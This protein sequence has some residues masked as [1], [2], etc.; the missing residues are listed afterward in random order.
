MR[1]STFEAV[2][3]IFARRFAKTTYNFDH[4]GSGRAA[5]FW[6]QQLVTGQ[7]HIPENCRV[8]YLAQGFLKRLSKQFI[9]F[10]L[11]VF[12]NFYYAFEMIFQIFLEKS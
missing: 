4:I 11:F 8:S 10:S 12:V 9:V 2:F 1:S 5:L 3:V 6:A 7:V